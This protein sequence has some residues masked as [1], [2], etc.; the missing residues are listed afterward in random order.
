[1]NNEEFEQMLKN[2]ELSKKELSELVELP[3]QTLMNWKRNNKAPS[4]VK[5]W[6]ENYKKA[7]KY[8]KIRELI[9]DEFKAD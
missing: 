1:M 9:K 7:K 4:W 3:Y 8:E 2:A 6:L 5:S